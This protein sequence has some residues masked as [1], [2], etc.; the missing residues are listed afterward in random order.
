MLHAVKVEDDTR[1]MMHST[2]TRYA[3]RARQW[4]ATGCFIAAASLSPAVAANAPDPQMAQQLVSD[5]AAH[6]ITALSTEKSKFRD[7]PKEVYA[8]VDRH[9]I[10]HVDF[11]RM[12]RWVL[13][14]HWRTAT[15]EQRQRFVSEF[16]QFLIRFY[17]TALIEYTKEHDIPRDVMSFLPLRDGSSTKRLIVRS[18]VHPATGG[19][20]IP[21][22]YVMH[23]DGRR[24][25]VFD[26]N[27]DGISMVSTYR[28]SFASEIRRVGLDGL[29]QRLAERNRQLALN[30]TETHPR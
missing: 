28:S 15:P 24:W 26:V 4:I 12:S 8:L 7:N 5:A 9:L 29:I 22:N 16:R 13:G 2:T 21:V 6:M 17:T 27:V 3:H 23:F 18:E 30:G 20:T 10:P 14:K 1:L 11:E 25:M 19:P